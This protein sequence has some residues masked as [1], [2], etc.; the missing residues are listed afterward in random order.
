MLR[1]QDLS[2]NT[3]PIEFTVGEEE[4]NIRFLFRTMGVAGLTGTVG[5]ASTARAARRGATA[6]P[7]MEARPKG[8]GDRAGT[9]RRGGI[10]QAK[11]PRSR[12]NGQHNAAIQDKTNRHSTLKL[13]SWELNNRS[14][15]QEP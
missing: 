4:Q 13:L 15:A 5:K 3:Y 2:M 9:G 6:R 14:T 11:E 1:E 12:E 7:E 10:P 8:P